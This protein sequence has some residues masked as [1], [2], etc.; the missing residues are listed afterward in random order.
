[1]SCRHHLALKVNTETGTITHTWPGVELEDMPATCALDVAEGPQGGRMTF[2]EVGDVLG[3][4]W[5]RVRQVEQAALVKC[6]AA[7][8][9]SVEVPTPRS[10]AEARQ[11]RRDAQ[12]ARRRRLVALAHTSGGVSYADAA[13]TLLVT[14]GTIGVDAA[15][16]SE[17]GAVFVRRCGHDLYVMPPAA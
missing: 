4:T 9:A 8:G 12:N 16:L 14:P 2:R 11:A 3:L 7:F 5:A 15:V 6:R 1:V 10:G 13:A 17:E